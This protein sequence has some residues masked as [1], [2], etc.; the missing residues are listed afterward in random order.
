MNFILNTLMVFLC[1]GSTMST[2]VPDS[3]IASQIVWSDAHF[4]GELGNMPIGNGDIAGNVWIEDATGDLLVYTAKSDAFDQNAQP[5]KVGRM[6]YTFDPPLWTGDSITGLENYTMV[7]NTIVCQDSNKRILNGTNVE[8]FPSSYEN[9][10]KEAAAKCD[11]FSMCHSFSCTKTGH[12]FPMYQLAI[13]G[14]DD[15]VKN[16]GDWQF[17]YKPGERSFSQTLN[18]TSG[19]VDIRTYS[20]Y[21][22]KVLIDANSPVLRIE[23]SNTKTTFNIKAILEI[24][25][26]TIKK[27][28]LGRGF[29]TTRYDIPDT[30]VHSPPPSIAS[31]IVWYHR[32]DYLLVNQSGNGYYETT[33][34]RHGVDPTVMKDPFENLT[35]G[36][37]L[38]GS[39]GIKKTNYNT[40]VG[41]K[42][43][44]AILEATLLTAQTK[45]ADEWLAKLADIIDAGATITHQAKSMAHE[46][47]WL[48]FWDRS[49]ITLPGRNRSKEE[50]NIEEKYVWTRYLDACDGRN[51]ASAIKFNGQ[52]FT[53]DEGKG[54][55]YRDW[56]ACYWFQNTRQ[57][58]YNALA[59][60]DLDIMRPLFSF[61][62]KSI[63]A[64][65]ARTKAEFN[66]SGG[67]WPETMTQFGMYNPGDWGCGTKPSGPSSNHYIRFH[68]TGSL[69][70][71]LF[72][73]DDYTMTQDEAVLKTN[74]P[75]LTTVLEYFRTR[76]PHRDANNKTDMFPAQAIETYQC[77]NPADRTQCVTNP[78]TDISG[79]MAVLSRAIKLPKS[80]VSDQQKRIW[81][82]QMQ[83]LPSI[84]TGN[85]PTVILPWS[86]KYK[87]AAGRHNSENTALYPVHPFRLYG[88]GK[89]NLQVAQDT[90]QKRHSPCNSG[91]CQDVIDAAML[92]LTDDA[93]N[94]VAQRASA[95]SNF[96]WSGYAG[97]YQDY[98]PSEDHYSFMRT[99]IH[100][101]LVSPLDDEKQS[102]LLFPT[103]P[104]EKWDIDFKL[105]GPL[106][107]TIEAA[108]I[109][110]KLTKLI[111]TPVERKSDI[112]VLN[113]KQDE[114]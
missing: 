4:K 66:I 87:Y 105:K 89:P 27:T 106:D 54:P 61:Y 38:G 82:D 24:Y 78:T 34:R 14:I 73:L 18:L 103:W 20:G 40:L 88:T 110:G 98:E 62:L 64:I 75:I 6:R 48:S 56:G 102:I 11:S 60:N 8:W 76:Y 41:E 58:Y 95:T 1:I 97:H 90:Y 47:W 99:A 30:V 85:T 59:A 92:N 91:W 46:S 51:A 84:P 37:H 42:L 55:D 43:E 49:F 96:R 15:A 69:E 70:M 32:N 19:S 28:N 44:S 101:M 72:A 31:G 53:V 23:A 112:T 12:A 109:Q 39:T 33:V 74:M 93:A 7:D 107:T 16:K 3:V 94:K 22:V 104:V 17:Y 35:F 68:T 29:C 79:L 36:G 10:P 81:T 45:T 13:D 67:Y 83:T 5:V 100:Y 25:R 71:A 113:C 65:K 86:P 21:W 57:S 108:C 80:V 26:N 50:K 63:D 114:Y 2:L 77:P 111:V 52:A 9:C